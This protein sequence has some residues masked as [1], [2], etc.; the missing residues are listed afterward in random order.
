MANATAYRTREGET[1]R[2]TVERLVALRQ[3]VHALDFTI[4]HR[5]E[6]APAYGNAVKS[7]GTSSYNYHLQLGVQLSE[8][9]PLKAFKHFRAAKAIARRARLSK[10][11]VETANRFILALRDSDYDGSER[12]SHH[13]TALMKSAKEVIRA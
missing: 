9:A 11:R 2:S 10:R 4:V 13:K 8:I 7:I 1:P 12:V 5:K 6:L 3:H